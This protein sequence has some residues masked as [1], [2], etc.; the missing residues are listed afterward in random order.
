MLLSIP[1]EHEQ[2]SNRPIWPIYGNL[3]G[4]TTPGQSGSGSN[5]NKRV[6]SLPRSSELEPHYQMQFSVILRAIVG[7]VALTHLHGIQ[8]VISYP[9]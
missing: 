8:S 7:L 6:L 5:G 9:H 3:T 2:F 1:I 4:T